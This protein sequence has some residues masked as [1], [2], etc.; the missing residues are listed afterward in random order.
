M[1][2]Y[3]IK[4]ITLFLI[5]V[6]CNQNKPVQSDVVAVTQ[7]KTR[8][9]GDAELA[10]AN[11]LAF[12]PDNVLF[13]GDSK[14]AKVL[15]VQ[16]EAQELKDPVPYNLEGFDTMIAEKLNLEP[17]DVIINDM[18]VHPVSQEAYVSI[19]MGHEPNAASVVAIVSPVNQD[20]RFLEVNDSNS[21]SVSINN[22]ASGD[23]TFWNE[24]PATALSITDIDYH[25]GFV[26][27]AGLTNGEFASTLRKIAYPFSN[28]Q[29]VVASIEN[30]H[31][32]HTQMETRAPIRSMLFA[33]IDGESNLIASYTCTPLV[34]IPTAEIT[35]GA[36]ITGKTIAE[37]GYGNAPIDMLVVTTQG[38]DGSTSK[39]LLVTHKNRGGTMV[40]FNS[41]V[42][43]A[44]GKG[45]AGQ[46]AM[47]ASGLEGIQ[48]IPT[49]NIM[50]LD[51]Q[52]PQMLGVVRRNIETGEIDLVSELT[53]T[54]LRLS[55]FISE[56]DFPDYQYPE[57]QEG[58]KQYHDM[59]KQ[60]EGYPQLT[61]KE[62]G[63]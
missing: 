18:K 63:R 61:S 24:T 31:A 52:N 7:K 15:A 43:G 37:L 41:V 48:Q 47:F 44:K 13:I 49:A 5:A 9:S 59:V 45:M 30:Y 3:S 6:G 62:M 28:S 2:N 1:K 21:S 10:G 57:V 12:G 11:I 42:A 19:K 55:D 23:L 46:R 26:Y 8:I 60:M 58:T 20:I 14:G 4:L 22:P 56:Y 27:V 39:S 35:G 40:P 54:F 34:T 17:R 36:S 53:G 38:F 16:T 33:D 25:N 51:V 29:E 50:Q 32:V